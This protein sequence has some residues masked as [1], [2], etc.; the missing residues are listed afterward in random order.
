[1]SEAFLQSLREA[2]P[3]QGT[4]FRSLL[5]FLMDT[6]I[7]ISINTAHPAYIGYIPGGGLYS[8]GRGRFSGRRDQP[9]IASEA[10]RLAAE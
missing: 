1:M 10:K 5:Q 9:I 8:F 2:P 4:D 7:P 3:E 6:V